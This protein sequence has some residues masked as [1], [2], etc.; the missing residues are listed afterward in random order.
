ME[1]HPYEH[2]QSTHEHGVTRM[3]TVL[4]GVTLIITELH[5]GTLMSA[6]RPVCTSGAKDKKGGVMYE[7]LFCV[8]IKN[9]TRGWHHL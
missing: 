7:Q 2:F 8:E 1:L 6:E 4:Q 9:R 5:G 3:G